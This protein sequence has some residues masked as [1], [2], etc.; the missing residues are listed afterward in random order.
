MLLVYG[1]SDG[2]KIVQG[3]AF[4]G[5]IRGTAGVDTQE[6]RSGMGGDGVN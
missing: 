5:K 2:D 3:P 1:F 4:P 6:F